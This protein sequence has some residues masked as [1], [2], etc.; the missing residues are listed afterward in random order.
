MFLATSIKFTKIKCKILYLP[1][2][3]LLTEVINSNI[4]TK[5][6]L[7]IKGVIN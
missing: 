2:W 7:F 5:G 6:W 3:C 1:H 4:S